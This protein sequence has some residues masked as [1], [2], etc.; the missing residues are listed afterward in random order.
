MANAELTTAAAPP[1]SPRISFMFCNRALVFN[2]YAPKRQ[3]TALGLIL[4]PPL[5]K[6]IPL[7][8]NA[9]GLASFAPPL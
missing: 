8:T 2:I 4:I 7:P 9:S 6:V 3:L 5:S 1:I